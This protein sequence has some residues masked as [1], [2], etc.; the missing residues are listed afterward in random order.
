MTLTKLS[1][2]NFRC[3]AYHGV[4]TAEKKLGGQYQI[5]I[6]LWYDAGPAIKT[7]ALTN[8]VNYQNVLYTISDFVN[9]ENYNL[10]ETLAGAILEALMREFSMLEE[11]TI[12]I[13]KM[14]VPIRQ[15]VDYV[16]VESH[17][18]RRERRRPV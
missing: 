4:D 12:R 11:A 7:D 6:D 17:I 1:I 9:V 16:Q 5:D 18:K 15:I 8:A 10:I 14:N 2:A 13:R 3:Y